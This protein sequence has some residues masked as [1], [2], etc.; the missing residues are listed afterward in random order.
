MIESIRQLAESAGVTIVTGAAVSR[1]VT[2]D[3]GVEA[4]AHPEPAPG[5]YDYDTTEFDTNV[6]DR[7]ELRRVLEGEAESAPDATW[8]AAPAPTSATPTAPT[9]TA[10]TPAAAR[11]RAAASGVAPADRTPARV[12]GV[13]YLD[14]TGAAHSID[15]D[16][17]VAATDLRHVET[18]MLLPELQT[19]PEKYWAK[20][21]AGPSAVLIYLGVSGAVPELAHHTLFF[22]KS[23]KADFEKIFGRGGV[24]AGLAKAVGIGR[25]ATTSVPSPASIYVCRPSATDP[26]VAPEGSENLFV[27][28]PIPAD[29]G[30]GSGGEDGGGDARVEAIADEAIAQIGEWAGI[31]DLASRITVR[32][33][34]G[35]ADFANDLNTWNG[36]ALGPAHT[37]AQ[38]AFFRA[39]NVSKKVGGLYYAG[40]STIPGIGLP[41]CLI[42]AE[43]V[44]KRLR[45][46]TSTT[47]LPEPL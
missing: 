14:S 25:K 36:T 39:G 6:V 37:L 27:L 12:S 7:D 1:I 30:I 33:T 40:G 16:I 46:D 22:T 20:K 41:M 18:T 10:P 32:R 43:L 44:I 47:A 13:Q 35:P 29:P 15:A 4:A 8:A 42:S 5:P 31:P 17:V 23:W 28:V 11:G 26:E 34:I 38:S 21:T 45:G 2:T 3:D 9:P 19:Y 24:V